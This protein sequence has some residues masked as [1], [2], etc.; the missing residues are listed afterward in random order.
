MSK[1]NLDQRKNSKKRS[2]HD[3]GSSLYSNTGTDSSPIDAT[4]EEKVQPSNK[5]TIRSVSYT[6]MASMYN[7]PTMTS[8]HINVTPEKK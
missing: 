3:L 2:V 5:S 8:S 7:I 6:D 1:N 4:L